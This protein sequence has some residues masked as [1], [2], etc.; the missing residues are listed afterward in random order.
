MTGTFPSRP[1]LPKE[2]D[3]LT[4]TLHD[5][6]FWTANATDFPRLPLASRIHPLHRI[7]ASID[8]DNDW[9]K[10]NLW[11]R[12]LC[13]FVSLTA[14]APF[15]N[16]AS[17][18]EHADG[19]F[20]RTEQ[21]ILLTFISKLNTLLIP[22]HYESSGDDDSGDEGEGD[23][24]GDLNEDEADDADAN[25]EVDKGDG[26]GG[27]NATASPALAAP[28]PIPPVDPFKRVLRNRCVA[29]ALSQ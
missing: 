11:D 3:A 17:G 1:L 8:L 6:I 28:A 14:A 22:P 25:N 21:Q 27:N 15:I 9:P 13:V 10:W 20:S 26:E 2:A 16:Q 29:P 12:F 4:T 18:E 24:Q 19:D 23:N 7:L 5:L